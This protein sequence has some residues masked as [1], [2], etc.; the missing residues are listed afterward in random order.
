MVLL[1]V[2]GAAMTGSL[3]LA[4]LFAATLPRTRSQR[5][6]V[7]IALMAVLTLSIPFCVFG[8][9]QVAQGGFDVGTLLT[10]AWL[11]LTTSYILFEEA[12]ARLSMAAEDYAWR[13]RTALL[14][15][16]IGLTALGLW[17][18]ASTRL[19]LDG[20]TFQ[21][22]AVAIIACAALGMA[23]EADHAGPPRRGRSRWSLFA[24]GALTGFRL[25]VQLLALTTVLWEA[26]L[27]T[28]ATAV[29]VAAP[30]YVIL[31]LCAALWISRVLA[32]RRLAAPDATRGVFFVLVA[33]GT[34]IPWVIGKSLGAGNLPLWTGDDLPDGF[35][36][37]YVSPAYGLSVFKSYSKW[38]IN[39]G[40]A[41]DFHPHGHWVLVAL[42]VVAAVATDRMLARRARAQA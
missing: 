19:E 17:H 10:A 24:P 26:L 1:C 13:P 37:G 22:L 33:F 27:K 31:Y 3:T 35:W 30:A 42:A 16:L 4:A 6:V 40:G 12:A 23:T 9:V 41:L 39:T 38:T 18:Q 28:S 20:M 21:F 15:Q 36:P 8:A 32:P 14:V 7:Q 2:A 29:V 25:T 5:G 11:V 34:L